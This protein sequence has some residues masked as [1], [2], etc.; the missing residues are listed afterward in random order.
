[1][2][3]SRLIELDSGWYHGDENGRVVLSP[4]DGYR[5]AEA[6]CP[7]SRSDRLSDDM[8]LLWSDSMLAV[9]LCP[10]LQQCSPQQDVSLS[11]SLRRPWE[12]SKS[13]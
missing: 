8:Y 11:D 3:F 4:G 12:L 13:T 6:R 9:V 1:M 10:C 2:W 7:N 5:A